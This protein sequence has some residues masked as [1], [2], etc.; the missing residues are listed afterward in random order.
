MTHLDHGIGIHLL[1]N[2][3]HF[4]NQIRQKRRRAQHAQRVTGWCGIQYDAIEI[5]LL[6]QTHHLGEGHHFIYYVC[7]CHGLVEEE[8]IEVVSCQMRQESMRNDKL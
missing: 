2:G 8:T 4:L 1:R 5:S 6:D 3:Q 7:V